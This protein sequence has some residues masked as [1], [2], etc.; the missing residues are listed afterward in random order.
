MICCSQA[1]IRGLRPEAPAP[2]HRQRHGTPTIIDINDIN[3]M[4][5]IDDINI[6]SDINDINDIDSIDNIIDIDNISTL[7]I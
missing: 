2:R 3:I 4:I 5:D 7:I 1:D 6:V